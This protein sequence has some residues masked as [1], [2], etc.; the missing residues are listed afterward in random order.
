MNSSVYLMTIGD[1]NFASEYSVIGDF[2]YVQRRLGYKQL[3]ENLGMYYHM[4]IL[5][6][7]HKFIHSGEKKVKLSPYDDLNEDDVK[8]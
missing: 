8:W 3:M 2:G 4:I 7:Q 1:K 5:I 6:R